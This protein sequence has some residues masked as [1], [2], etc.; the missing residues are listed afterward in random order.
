MN[1]D[2]LNPHKTATYVMPQ[3]KAV[4]VAVNKAAC[5]SLK[6]LVADI[7]GEDPERFYRSVSREISRSMCIHRRSMF[8]NT[9]MLHRLSDEELAGIGPDQG[10]FIFTVIRHPAARLF[11]GW[12]S[13]FLLREPRWQHTFGD[14]PWFPRVPETTRDIV[15]D[16]HRFVESVREEPGQAVM[17][18]RHFM[19]QWRMLVPDRMPYSK[20]YETREIP[21]LMTDFEAHLRAHGYEG[22]VKL[23][24]SNETPLQPIAALFT[25][26]VQDVIRSVWAED[27][28]GLGYDDV[29]PAKLHPGDEY[30]EHAFAEI[31][32]LI[33]RAERIG[34][35]A[36]KA[37]RLQRA[38]REAK[39]AAP[40]AENGSGGVVGRVR[41]RIAGA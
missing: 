29:M 30:P 34:D 36:L 41:R 32:R 5:T 25:P 17:R 9:P 23:R 37:Q 13:K 26:A 19:A 8:R 21:Q 10:W 1:R 7:Q 39:R 31:H 4:Y 14:A 6:W 28:E 20:I 24:Q 3:Y 16:F 11:S 15:E 33:E 2:Q 12:Q 18:D 38:Q 27:F 35:L 40:P 22:E